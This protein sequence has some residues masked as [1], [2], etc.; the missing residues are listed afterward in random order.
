MGH[1]AKPV[2]RK[3]DTAFRDHAFAGGRIFFRG[4]GGE[5]ELG[6]V[7]RREN[8][9]SLSSPKHVLRR[10][11]CFQMEGVLPSVISLAM[12]FRAGQPAYSL[13]RSR[14]CSPAAT[15]ATFKNG[16][17]VRSQSRSKYVLRRARRLR[18]EGGKTRNAPSLT[19]TWS[20]GLIRSLLHSG[21]VY[22]S[23]GEYE[24]ALADLDRA[25]A[26]DPVQWTEAAFGLVV[27]ADCHAR[28]GNE[29]AA[30]A[31]CARLHDDFWTGSIEGAPGGS[32]AEIADKL[33][34]I[35]AGAR[36]RRV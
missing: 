15:A 22:R 6:R 1:R 11:H 34:L 30:L 24:K 7:A 16:A 12:A 18:C 10:F 36:G 32:K 17:R 21:E 19:S 3:P 27:Q 2:V 33:R 8:G 20:S 4:R 14:S 5:A 9:S 29:A 31:C 26:I 35:A 25:E 13:A 23:I 28:L